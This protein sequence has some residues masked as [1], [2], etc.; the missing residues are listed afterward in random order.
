M[1]GQCPLTPAAA[2]GHIDFESGSDSKSS[3]AGNASF[4]PIFPQIAPDNGAIYLLWG[5]DR[6]WRGLFS[7]A[8]F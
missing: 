3:S 6:E 5:L 8:V 4:V 1:S 2:F 7:V